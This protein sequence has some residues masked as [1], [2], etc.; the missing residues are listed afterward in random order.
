[1]CD[2]TIWL[3]YAHWL[4]TSTDLEGSTVV[5]Y[6]RKCIRQ[7]HAKYKSVPAHI[8][9][10]SVLDDTPARKETWLKGAVR[11]IYVQAF[12][13]AT[14]RNEKVAKQA[15][16]MYTEHRSAVA[17]SFRVLDTQASL[18]RNAAIQCLGYAAGRGGEEF[19]GLVIPTYN[20]M[21]TINYYSSLVVSEK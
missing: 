1:L 6:M 15:S 14:A 10:F 19:C 8:E 3:Q 13:D 2:P 20:L 12:H 4:L 9:F 18:K 7:V 21:K 16:P 17:R 11:Q 5:E